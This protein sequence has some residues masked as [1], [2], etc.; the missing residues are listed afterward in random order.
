MNEIVIRLSFVAAMMVEL[1][2]TN[3]PS[4]QVKTFE[5]IE[6][7]SRIKEASKPKY[8]CPVKLTNSRMVHNLEMDVYT[9]VTNISDT[10]ITAIAFGSGH[11]DNF[12]QTHT[13]YKT[14]L[15]SEDKI[16]KGDSQSMHWEVLMEEPFGPANGKPGISELFV[17]KVAFADGRGL[18]I[19]DFEGTT[20][21]FKF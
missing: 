12:G 13:P 8:P 18:T 11:T 15:T 1:S 4:P 14:D 20:C 9:T 10:D 21:D 7:E 5:Q 2:C 3:T 6:E 16:K 19:S 17:T